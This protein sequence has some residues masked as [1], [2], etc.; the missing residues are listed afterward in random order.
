MLEGQ[1]PYLNSL[2]GG[3]KIKS[4]W[5]IRRGRE[6]ENPMYQPAE[7]HTIVRFRSLVET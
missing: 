1:V 3:A 6:C 4:S 2:D 5:H 7:F